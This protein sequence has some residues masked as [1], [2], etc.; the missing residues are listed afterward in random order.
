MNISSSI[1]QIFE[2]AR[3]PNR[4]FPVMARCIKIQEELG[5]FSEA[6]LHKLGYLPH[7]KMKEPIEGEAADVIICIIDTLQTVYPDLS[8]DEVIIMLD[9]ALVRKSQ[10]WLVGINNSPAKAD[11]GDGSPKQ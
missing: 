4:D 9:T 8:I 7:K 11:E 6:F 10:K 3:N 2:I 1:R 5:E